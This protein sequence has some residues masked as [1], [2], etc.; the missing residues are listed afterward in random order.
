VAKTLSLAAGLAVGY[1]L[2]A[3]A[4]REKYDQ[5]A[6]TARRW[7]GRPAVTRAQA[8][9]TDTPATAQDSIALDGAAAKT[10]TA[11]PKKS[12]RS[13]GMAGSDL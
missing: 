10:S 9:V 13:S 2:G 11:R 1:V 4:G 12:G 5:L 8:A 3:R 7:A 6:E